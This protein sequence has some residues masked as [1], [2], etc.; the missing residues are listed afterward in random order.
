MAEAIRAGEQLRWNEGSRFAYHDLGEET[1][2][3]VDGEHYLLRGDARPLAPLL[4][5]GARIPM[6]ALGSP[7]RGLG[8]ARAD[9]R[10]IQPGLRILRVSH[11]PDPDS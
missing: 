11:A 9:H 5:A 2:L 8:P 7:G 1:A 6:A 10:P 4:C 3:F